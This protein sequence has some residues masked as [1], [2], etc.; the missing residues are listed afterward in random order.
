MNIAPEW[1][2]ELPWDI[3]GMKIYKIKCLP[4]EWAQKSQD[5][6]YFKMLS[7]KRKYLIGTG[8]VGRYTDNLYCPFEK[9][10]FKLSAH[11]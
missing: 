2:E 6:R 11:G 7:T 10:P 9:C 3:D 4:R 1:M 5:L 8:K